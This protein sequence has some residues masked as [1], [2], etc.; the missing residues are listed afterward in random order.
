VAAAT[1]AL[2]ALIAAGVP[3]EIVKFE[4]DSRRVPSASK[5]STR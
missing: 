4:H 2:A 5:P 1:P 3:H